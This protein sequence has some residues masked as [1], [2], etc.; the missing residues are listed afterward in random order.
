M[1]CKYCSNSL[2]EGAAACPH[3]G[4]TVDPVDKTESEI[5]EAVPVDGSTKRPWLVGLGVGILVLVVGGVSFALFRNT[6]PGADFSERMPADVATYVSLDVGELVSAESKAVIGEF[7]GLVELVS[8]EEFDVDTAFEDLLEEVEAEMGPDLNYSEDI[9]SWASGSIAVGVLTS[10]DFFEQ[11]GLVWV[12]GRD[13]AALAAFL[14]KMERLAADEGVVTSRVTVSGVDFIT[15]D[16]FDG[17]LVGQVGPD[18]LAV[19]DEALAEVV[20]A[21]TPETSLN[22][23]PGFAD[24]ISLLPPNAIATFAYSASAFDYGSMFAGTLGYGPGGFGDTGPGDLPDTGWMVG[25]FSVENG[26]IR[27][28]GVSGIDPDLAFELSS[29]SPALDELPGDDAIFFA[30]LAGIGQGLEAMA[31]MFGPEIDAELESATGLTMGQILGLLE[32]DAGLAVWPSSEPEIPVGAGFVGVGTDDAAPVVDRL[33]QLILESGGVV[34]T[35][36]PG[37]YLY[38]NLVVFGSRGP[39]TLISSDRTL[40]QGAPAVSLTESALYTRARDLIGS[41]FVPSF[42]ADIDGILRL[43]DGFVNDPQVLE[44]FACNPVR[45]IAGG[46][47]IDGDLARSV[48][49]IEVEAPATCG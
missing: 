17:M 4:R 1:N 27:V 18:L 28:D 44:G 24:R 10:D 33:N 2:P 35:E 21:L 48:A 43:V 45:F 7:G 40:L 6:A 34:A 13:E 19:S 37:G 26:N 32:V 25:S 29:D 14:A 23:A 16:M 15:S 11:S 41:G 20:L 47:R 39:L 9:A 36:V 12:S 42:G 31:E 8:G 38:E 46:S 5:I 22:G 3:C 30:R 49:V